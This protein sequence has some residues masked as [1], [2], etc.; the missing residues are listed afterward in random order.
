[1]RWSLLPKPFFFKC[2]LIQ[3]S[4]TYRYIKVL[5]FNVIV[6]PCH[7]DHKQKS[8]QGGI[9]YISSNV[10]VM[11]TGFVKLKLIILFLAELLKSTVA[12][13]TELWFCPITQN[14]TD[15]A[16]KNRENNY[17]KQK[18]LLCQYVHV[19]I[20]SRLKRMLNYPFKKKMIKEKSA[21]V[22]LSGVT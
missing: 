3:Y 11:K 15:L 16:S 7:T 10:K 13:N 4:H 17:S 8:M 20:V 18:L 1:M 14:E 2:I 22:K 5:L 12:Q 9:S 19:S 21:V 6:I